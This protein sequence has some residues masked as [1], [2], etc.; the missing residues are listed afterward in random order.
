MPTPNFFY[1]I[2]KPI[3]DKYSRF[4]GRI[5]AL[6]FDSDGGLNNIVFVNGGGYII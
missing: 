6:E 1:L 3:L 5:I 2:G 4:K